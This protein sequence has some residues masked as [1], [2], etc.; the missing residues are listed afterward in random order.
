MSDIKKT[1]QKFVFYVS[2]TV[3]IYLPKQFYS[4]FS[5]FRYVLLHGR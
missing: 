3:I 1:K 4:L 2:I 5:F